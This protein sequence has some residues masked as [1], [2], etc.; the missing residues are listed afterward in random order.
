ML[1]V[2]NRLATT[3]TV[4]QQEEN[5]TS[6]TGDIVPHPLSAGDAGV[7][8]VGTVRCGGEGAMLSGVEPRISGHVSFAVH[9]T[10]GVQPNK[11]TFDVVIYRPISL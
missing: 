6:L 8:T 7:S 11:Q 3:V 5:G 1:R 4:V 9:T 2:Q 10:G